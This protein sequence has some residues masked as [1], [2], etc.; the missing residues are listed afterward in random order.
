MGI[1]ILVMDIYIY[2]YISY[3]YIYIIYHYRSIK[4]RLRPGRHMGYWHHGRYI[5][6]AFYGFCPN[7]W[8]LYNRWLYSQKSL[9]LHPPNP[10]VQKPSD[11]LGAAKPPSFFRFR[12]EVLYL[13]FWEKNIQPTDSSSLFPS[14][15][16]HNWVVYP[17]THP[18]DPLFSH[19]GW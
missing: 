4:N 11:P 5:N 12:Q 6:I 3:I 16:S 15:N 19:Y 13:M 18:N 10:Q 14:L 1:K 7:L 17:Q 9:Q 2:M 8:G